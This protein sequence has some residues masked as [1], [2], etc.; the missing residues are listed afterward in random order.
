M[1]TTYILFCCAK[2]KIPLKYGID[3]QVCVLI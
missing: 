1:T 2:Y 3:K